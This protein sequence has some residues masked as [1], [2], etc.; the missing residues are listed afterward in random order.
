MSREIETLTPLSFGYVL[1][2][3]DEDLVF[4]S[5]VEQ[6]MEHNATHLKALNYTIDILNSVPWALRTSADDWKLKELNRFKN[7]F[8]GLYQSATTEDDWMDAATQVYIRSL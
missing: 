2:Y 3:K 7:E 1:N 8:F 5:S 4:I 6:F